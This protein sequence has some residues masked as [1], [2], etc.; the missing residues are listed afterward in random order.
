MS[1]ASIGKFIP[2]VTFDETLLKAIVLK[3]SE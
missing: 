3:I 2:D 1:N